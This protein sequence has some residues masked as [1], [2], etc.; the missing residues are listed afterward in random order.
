MEHST[1]AKGTARAAQAGFGMFQCLLPHLHPRLPSFD[2]VL[3]FMILGRRYQRICHLRWPRTEFCFPA[4][5]PKPRQ[6]F[7]LR[8]DEKHWSVLN[9]LL[10]LGRMLR[11]QLR[12]KE[13]RRHW[14]SDQLEPVSGPVISLLG[15]FINLTKF[16]HL[17]SRF[18]HQRQEND[19]SSL[20]VGTADNLREA[21]AD[22]CWGFTYLTSK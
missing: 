5:H 8:C 2:T 6:S 20:S 1:E 10:H 18:I 16:Q 9:A 7:V 12:I 3:I 22:A 21:G 13:E 14:R 15:S 4:L 17:K 11:R 19:N